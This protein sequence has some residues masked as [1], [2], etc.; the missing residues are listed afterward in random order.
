MD[1][2]IRKIYNEQFTA[3]KYQQLK[4]YINKAHDYV[5]GFRISES[6]VFLTPGLHQKLI[7][8]SNEI[9]EVLFQPDFIAKTNAAILP[10][11]W[12]PGEDKHTTFLQLDFG[13]CRNEAGELMPQLIEVQGFPSLYFFQEL[14]ARAYK[15]TFEIPDYYTSIF[16]G[17]TTEDYVNLFKKVIVGNSQPENVVLLE[18]DPHN[19]PTAIDFYATQAKLDIPIV[20]ISDV[21]KSGRDLYYLDKNGKKVGIE[22]IYNRVIFDELERRPEYIKEYD[23]RDEINAEW[24][25]HPHWFARISKF[26][27]PMIDSPYNPTSIYLNDLK[28]IPNDLENYVL[29]PLFS[30]SGSGVV[31][32]VKKEDIEK[33]EKPEHYI[34][35]KKVTYQPVIETLN[36]PTKCEIRMLMIWEKGAP[37]PTIVN[38][39]VRLS[40]GQMV[41]VKYNKDKDWVGAS[42]A[43]YDS[44]I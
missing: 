4:D 5:P 30:F 43:L 25:G 7:E 36:D 32:D 22:K 23:L 31:I 24:I 34:L 17:R 15:E 44:R 27:L 9:S 35:Q 10:N 20:C 11:Q 1:S 42:V 38:N 29:K 12:V 37:K 6:P 40:K 28:N 14:I 3:E 2:N 26:I 41:G 8:A 21:K 19:Q 13:I 33:V 16:G 39:L 18:I